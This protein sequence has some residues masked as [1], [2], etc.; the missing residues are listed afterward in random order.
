[1]YAI[2]SYYGFS[3]VV[4][5]TSAGMEPDIDQNPLP[6]FDFTGVRIVYDIIYA[7]DETRFLAEARAA[8]C[9]TI[10]GFPM[11]KASYNFV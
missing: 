5:T 1:M 3:L 6:G 4:Q 2:R 7:P 11:L 8:G 9:R 10:N